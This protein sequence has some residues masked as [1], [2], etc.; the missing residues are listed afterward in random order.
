MW[1]GP[2]GWQHWGHI[3]LSHRSSSSGVPEH[4][5]GD[6]FPIDGGPWHLA[7]M[8][9]YGA[10]LRCPEGNH[11][12]IYRVFWGALQ[13]R[14]RWGDMVLLTALLPSTAHPDHVL[15]AHMGWRAAAQPGHAGWEKVMLLGG[16]EEGEAFEMGNRF[17]C[18]CLLG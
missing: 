17:S 16:M 6:T 2:R 7:E 15:E 1:P 12:S 10:S 4:C 14:T 8:A 11:G 13:V 5:T 9:R 3:M 18:L